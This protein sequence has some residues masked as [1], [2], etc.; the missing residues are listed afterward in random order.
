MREEHFA[1]LLYSLH[2]ETH[3]S[4]FLPSGVL[5]RFIGNASCLYEHA[6]SQMYG[7]EFICRGILKEEEEK[8]GKETR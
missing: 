5:M 3:N 7:C 1:L 8:G 2:K 6:G 4:A